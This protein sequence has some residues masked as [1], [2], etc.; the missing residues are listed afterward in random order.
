M[1]DFNTAKNISAADAQTFTGTFRWMAPEILR[2]GLL[3]SGGSY[4][5]F[6]ADSNQLLYPFNLLVWS[7]GCLLF[8]LLT[9]HEP[10]AEFKD[11]KTY[12][13]AR[14]R[15]PMSAYIKGY[16]SENKFIQ[17][18]KEHQE[19]RIW[20]QL[21]EV[22]HLCTMPMPEDR[23]DTSRVV[24]LLEKIEKNEFTSIESLFDQTSTGQSDG[25]LVFIC[26]TEVIQQRIS[27]TF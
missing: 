4:D 6:K 18:P 1:G 5:G 3:S 20:I 8:L 21:R 23:P 19:H 10:Y 27:R 2:E 14:E 24:E 7:L 13:S 25:Y 11:C 12:I 22:F 16:C 17:I 9:M 26:V 15:P